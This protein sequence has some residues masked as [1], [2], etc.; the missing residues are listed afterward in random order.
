MH[1]QSC[2]THHMDGVRPCTV[3]DLHYAACEGDPCTGCVPREAT[4]GYVC[5]ACWHRL[6]RAFTEW[7]AFLAAFAGEAR[8]VQPEPGGSTSKPSSQVPLSPLQ[9]AI[10]SIGRYHAQDARLWVETP[11]G[12]QQAVLFTR[13]MERAARAFP[14]AENPTKLPTTRCPNCRQRSLVYE[15][16]PSE[17]AD[18]TVHCLNCDHTM[19]H[20]S[21]ETL[22]LIEAQCCRRCRSD[23]GCIDR[24]C[25]CHR[26]APVPEWQRT[27]KGDTVPYDPNNPTH[28]ALREAA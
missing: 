20:A 9:L 26:F 19:D 27:S 24:A 14:R 16:A 11:Q 4:H 3:R 6:E 25:T 22:A 18:A 8:A 13:E 15:P 23:D 5:T 28:R 12:A 21:F 17:G 2:I 10:D 1:D 7:A